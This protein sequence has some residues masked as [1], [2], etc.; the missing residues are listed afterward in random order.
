MAFAAFGGH[1]QLA[2]TFALK[3]CYALNPQSITT[4]ISLRK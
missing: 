4:K 3:I 1:Q 2:A